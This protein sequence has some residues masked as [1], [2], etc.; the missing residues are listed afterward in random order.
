[1][2]CFRP[3]PASRTMSIKPGPVF[4]VGEKLL[5]SAL[6][7][8][9]NCFDSTSYHIVDFRASSSSLVRL[10]AARSQILAGSTM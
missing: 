3:G 9:S 5:T 2:S 4:G 10:S 7:L 6:P 8:T 1:M